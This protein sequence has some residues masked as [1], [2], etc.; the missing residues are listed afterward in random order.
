[1]NRMNCNFCSI[2]NTFVSDVSIIIFINGISN[3]QNSN[4]I[5]NSQALNTMGLIRS[6]SGANLLIS[7]C[8]FNNNIKTLFS[9]EAS[10]ITIT[11]C[12]IDLFSKTGIVST[13]SIK[14]NTNTHLLIHYHSFLCEAE[15]PL[16]FSNIIKCSC[17]LIIYKMKLNSILISFLSLIF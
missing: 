5:N 17:E 7:F 13:S 4:F 8:I 2:I 1:M 3:F 12:W 16:I 15:I 11:N 9:N 10:T 6:Y 14:T